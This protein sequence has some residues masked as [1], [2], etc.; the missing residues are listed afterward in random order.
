MG[1]FERI[2]Y[3]LNSWIWGKPVISVCFI[4]PKAY[5]L[6]RPTIN[7]CIGGAEVD[8]YLLA[9]EIAKDHRF[10]VK[11]IVGNYGQ[12]RKERIQNVEIIRARGVCGFWLA[13]FRAGCDIYFQEAASWGTLLVT[14][15]CK[16]HRKKLVYRTAS[17]GECNGEIFTERPLFK[18]VFHWCLKQASQVIVQNQEDKLNLM[19]I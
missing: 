11:F 1:F 8:L 10:D 18:R 9:V 4:A 13:M 17:Q 14:L 15:F 2:N 12:A 16:L 3:R 19:L 7:E 5:V 6:F